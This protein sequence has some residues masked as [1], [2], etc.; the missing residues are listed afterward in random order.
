MTNQLWRMIAR[1]TKLK[2]AVDIQKMKTSD[3]KQ[4]IINHLLPFMPSAALSIYLIFWLCYLLPGDLDLATGRWSQSS[5]ISKGVE[6]RKAFTS[7]L[8]F[9]SEQKCPYLLSRSSY[10]FLGLE[11][12]NKNRIWKLLLSP[13][14]NLQMFI[15][16][17][18]QV[19]KCLILKTGSICDCLV[20][21]CWC[22]VEV[23][24]ILRL[25]FI[26]SGLFKEVSIFN[27]YFC[28]WRFSY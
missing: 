3:G 28:F 1:A 16:S 6:N 27:I 20:F 15:V 17:I 14:L 25:I 18:F 5:F 11:S 26:F 8:G 19:L 23:W 10:V 9:L 13:L 7:H 22:K 12:H 21:T 2:T 4:A 24:G